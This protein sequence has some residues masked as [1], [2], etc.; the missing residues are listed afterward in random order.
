MA[1]NPRESIVQRTKFR[2]EFSGFVDTDKPARDE[3]LADVLEKEAKNLMNNLAGWELDDQEIRL[4]NADIDVIT[5]PP[6]L[7]RVLSISTCHIAQA[8]GV[9]LSEAC[10]PGT[11]SMIVREYEEG[12]WVHI[13]RDDKDWLASLKKFG[14][15]QSVLDVLKFALDHACHYAF[16]DRDG[17]IYPQLPKY[18]W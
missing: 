5:D 14:Y 12:W 9:W 11:T 6:E 10:H 3:A 13:N 8:D 16:I 7:F 17:Q 18:E 15:P 4:A 2:L 1:G